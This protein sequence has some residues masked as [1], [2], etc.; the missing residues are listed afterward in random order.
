MK[1]LNP[2]KFIFGFLG[3]STFASLVG[4]V[5]GTLAWYAYSARAAVSYSGTSVSSALQLK[6]G[7]ASIN[8]IPHAHNALGDH[9]FDVMH[10]EEEKYHND[11]DNNDYF[12][13]FANVGVGL[14]P[15]ILEYYLKN[16]GYSPDSMMPVTTGYFDPDD[17]TC[18]F[19]LKK[20]PTILHHQQD[21]PSETENYMK[22]SFIFKAVKTDL[23]GDTDEEI[24]ADPGDKIW[25][26]DAATHPHNKSRDGDVFKSVRAFIDRH[27]D[28]GKDFI[29]NP[30]AQTSGETKVGGVLDL[31]ND[32][33]FDYEYQNDLSSVGEIMYGEWYEYSGISDTPYAGPDEFV[34]LNGSGNSE[35]GTCFTSRHREG[36]KYYENLNNCRFKTAKYECVDAIR[37]DRHPITGEMR[38]FD[39]SKPT[40]VCETGDAA[41]NY[42]AHFDMYLWLEGW[43]YNAVD[44]FQMHQFDFG[45]TFEINKIQYE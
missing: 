34:D 7:L 9:F 11:E 25:L 38:N 42:I 26:V 12:C 16:T 29:V 35:H 30:M 37:P 32:Q 36:V 45:L 24:Y 6:I 20:S 15:E 41:H 43:D 8:E 44:D 4:T 21:I 39:D 33:Y 13:Y 3:L 1:K 17:P 2:A 14:D 40:H 19:S 5:S 18:E 22:F 31:T 23:S 10:L 27:N 28:I